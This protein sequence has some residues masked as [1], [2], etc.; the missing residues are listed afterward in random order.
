MHKMNIVE[1][2]KISDTIKGNANFKT[3][4]KKAININS[5]RSYIVNIL[6]P[7]RNTISRI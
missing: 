4:T 3:V 1:P 5:A 2:T 7:K 6:P